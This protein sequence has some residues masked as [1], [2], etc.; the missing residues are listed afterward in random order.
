VPPIISDPQ[1]SVVVSTYNRGDLL[2]DAVRSIL[3]QQDVRTPRFELIVV[4][5]NST[6]DHPDRHRAIRRCRSAR[7]L[8]LRTDAGIAHGRNAG[9]RTARAPI[10]AFTDD[11]VRAEPDW[12]GGHRAGLR[13][14]S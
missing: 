2:A 7:A 14:A 4:D 10:V 12:A 11:D 13:R 8:R 9:I 1:L 6:D 3:A 5:N